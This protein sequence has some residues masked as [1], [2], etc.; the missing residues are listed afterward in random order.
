MEI[1]HATN[2]TFSDLTAAGTVIADFWAPWCGPCRMVAPVLEKLAKD[3]PDIQIIKINVD[4]EVE[5]ATRFRVL[6]IPTLLLFRD[7]Q[8]AE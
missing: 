3:Y 8:L 1:K 6:S 5:L 2:Q 4:E 7:G